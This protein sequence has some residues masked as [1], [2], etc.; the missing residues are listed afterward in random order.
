[1]LRSRI[2]WTRQSPISKSLWVIEKRKMRINNTFG[3]L[4][5]ALL[6]CNDYKQKSYS[7]KET[8]KRVIVDTVIGSKSIT[9]EI[10]GSS[11]RK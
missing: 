4:V 8:L 2:H 7:K 11:Y 6:A 1:M 3:I 5:I 9:D 10:A